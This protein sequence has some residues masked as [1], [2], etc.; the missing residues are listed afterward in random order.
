MVARDRIP[1]YCAIV[2]TVSMNLSNILCTAVICAA[3]AVG[4]CRREAGYAGSSSCRECHEKFY[5]LWSTSHH[6]LAMQPVDAGFV[7]SVLEPPTNEIV[8]GTSSFKIDLSR[9]CMV[10]KGPAGSRTYPIEH[11]MGGKNVYYFLA[12]LDKGRLQVMPAAFDVR[13]RKWY[14]TTASM[15][16]HILPGDAPLDWKD[17]MLTFNTACYGCHVSQLSKNYDV[18]TDSYRTVW[19]EP[20]INCE[21]CHGKSAEHVEVCRA[22][23][24]NTVPADLKI[25]S[26][27]KMTTKQRDETCAPC[28]AKMRPLTD[29]FKP[30]DRFFDHY[31]LVCFE[32]NDFYPDGRDLGEN[33]TYTS[34]LTSPCVKSGKLECM[35]CHTSSGRYKFAADNFN[36]ACLPCHEERVRNAES[37]AHHGKT[38]VSNKCIACHMPMTQFAGMRRS[39][40]S[41]LPPTPATTVAFGSPNACGLC[42]KGRTAEWANQTVREWHTNDYQAPVLYRAG[43]IQSARK[44]EWAKLDEMFSFIG[45]AQSDPIVVT[46]LIRLLGPCADTRKQPVLR[47]S[48]RHP[49]PLVR[50]AAVSAL[51]GDLSRETIDVLFEAAKDEYRV[52]RFAAG[53]AIA[54][55]PD[56]AVP[57]DNRALRDRLFG[58]L[59]ESVLCMPDQW[60]AWYNM[61]IFHSDRGNDGKALESYE[62]SMRL[63]GDVVL[64]M[65]NASMIHARQG[66][67]DVALELLKKAYKT[68]PGSAVVNFNLGLA[69]AEQKKLSEAEKHL[70]AALRAEPAFDAAA[71]NLG[72]LLNRGRVTDEGITWC[73]KAVA[74]RPDNPKYISTLAYYLNAA[75]RKDEARRVLDEAVARGVKD[76]QVSAMRAQLHL[77]SQ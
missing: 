35:H 53:N 46:S 27:K 34:W 58:E 49:S 20:G 4:G 37:H 9:R 32:D 28:H 77:Q 25:I 57:A 24:K 55:V 60:S 48:A 8:I 47:K 23:P 50:S 15:V 38:S 44:G 41:M 6:G 5:T 19:R 29:S 18:K 70:R 17:P 13:A 43:L 11:A 3:L 51:K 59:L 66:R 42:H 26:M 21:T 68:E 76:E 75:G 31:D 62:H 10:E 45:N 16:R 30:G 54:P 63:R 67:M 2:R 14:N 1:V 72:V 71:Y 61:G 7:R 52:V 56:S 74:M 40:H 65:V 36:G 22:A 69:L 64:P 12:P 39:D 73:R 33:Y